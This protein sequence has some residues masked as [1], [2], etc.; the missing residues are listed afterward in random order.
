MPHEL[1]S[2][3][4]LKPAEGRQSFKG[5]DVPTIESPK[6]GGAIKSIDEKFSVNTVN[7]TSGISIP[8]PETSGRG[9]TPSLSLSY[10]SGS[11]NGPFGLGWD[12]SL[13]SIS[14]STSRKLPLYEDEEES[15][16]FL[17][18]EAEDLVPQF[19][20]DTQGKLVEDGKG[21]YVLEK[22]VSGK[23]LVQ[24]YLPRTEGAF[25]RIEK[26]TDREIGV[27]FWRVTS[28]A[29]VTTYFGL[30]DQ[31][32]ISDPDQ[33]GHTFQWL[34]E[35]VVDHTGSCVRYQYKQDGANRFLSK[36]FY[37]NKQPFDVPLT[38]D[39][40][41][42]VLPGEEAFF[43]C[44]ALDY[45]DFSR[46]GEESK[47][48]DTRPDCFSSYRSGFEIRT[49]RL[50]R[51]FLLFHHF[52]ELG[53]RTLVSSLDLTYKQDECL[54]LLES[55][56]EKG[57][58]R[59]PDG[60]YSEKSLPSQVFTY[61]THAWNT[62]V[63]TPVSD[64]QIPAGL[65]G[66]WQLTDLHNEGIP[67]LL[68]ETEGVWFYKRNLGDGQ[69]GEAV[70]VLE[71]PS[72][73]SSQ[74]LQF[75]DLDGDGR[76]QLVSLKKGN[77]G[78][79]PM[80]DE[81]KWQAFHHFRQ[82]PN[83][84][85]SGADVRSID[86]TGDGRA[87]LLVTEDYALTWYASAGKDGYGERVSIPAV[88]EENDGPALMFSDAGQSIFL[89]DM[90]GDGRADIV[91]IRPGE[92]CYW[93]NLGY[94]RFGKKITMGNAP[95]FDSPESFDA[96]RIML[97]D[98]DGTGPADLVYCGTHGFRIWLN[99]CGNAFKAE[100]FVIDGFPDIHSLSDVVLAD[101]LGTGTACIVWSSSLEKDRGTN[102]R[103][104]DLMSSRKPY[105]MTG[106][107][108][109]MGKEIHLEYKPSTAFY[110][111]DLK[112]GDPWAETV[113]FPVHC[114]R[115]VTTKD[116]VTGWTAAHSYRYRDAVYDHDEKEFRGFSYVE[117]KDIEMAEAG[118]AFR[119]RY[120]D[121]DQE[122]VLSRSWI[123]SGT[124]RSGEVPI[125]ASKL[126]PGFDMDSLSLAERRQA[127]R[128][129][130]GT[131]LKSEVWDEDG[132]LYQRITAQNRVELVQPKGQN[133]F[134]V[135]LQVPVETVTYD[136]EKNSEDPRI[137][138]SLVLE[139]DEYGNTL[140]SVQVAYP[141]MAPDLTLP[142]MARECQAKTV[143]LYTRNRL[144]CD[145]NTPDTYLL[146]QPS[147]SM[148]FEVRAPGRSGAL[149]CSDDFAE[150]EKLP[151]TLQGH[152]KILY[153]DKTL[154]NALPLHSIAFP[155]LVF[156]SYQMVGEQ[157]LYDE[158]FQG[159]VTP[160]MLAQG[161]Y[162]QEQD[163]SW[164]ARSGQV[165]Y[166][167]EGE[168]ADVAKTRFYSPVSYIDAFGAE[169]FV[170]YYRNY[171]LLVE[172]V[173][174]SLGNVS[175]VK[176]FDFRT[177]QAKRVSDLNG[178]QTEALYDELGM[179][180][181]SAVLGKGTEADSLEGQ[182]EITSA[183]EQKMMDQLLAAQD[184]LEIT[185]IAR[186]L[187]KKASAR[188]LY[189]PHL[190]SETGKPLATIGIVREE[191]D[192]RNPD[193][194]LQVSY[195]Y[196]S[197]LGVSILVKVQAE[198]APDSRREAGSFR[199]LGNGR[200]I[201]NNKGNAVMEFDPYFSDTPRYEDSAE[202]VEQGV[203]PILH[204]DPLGRLV[205]IDYPDGTFQKE[206]FDPWTV[207]S[208]DS[209]DCVMESAWYTKHRGDEAAAQSEIDAGT[210]SKICY[211]ALGQPAV[212]IEYL[213]NTAAERPEE[214]ITQAV[215]DVRGN[216][217]QVVDP[218]GNTVVSYKYDLLDRPLFQEGMDDGCRWMITDMEGKPVFSWDERGFEFE[219]RYDILK[220]PVL[221]IVRNKAEGWEKIVGRTVYGEDLL[222][223]DQSNKGA[224][225][226]R[227]LLG[228]VVRAYDTAGLA[229]TEAYD[230]QYLP[231]KTVRRLARDY[232]GMVDWTED[233]LESALEQERF[234]SFMK[235]DALGR[236]TEQ[237]MPDGSVAVSA[238]NEGGLLTSQT[239]SFPGRDE[240]VI[241]LRKVIYN[242][243]RQREYVSY[244]N[245]V[246]IRYSFDPLTER[247]DRIY[248]TRKDG[249]VLQDLN[250][251]YDAVGRVVRI[252]DKSIPTTFYAGQRVDGESR[253]TYDSL[254]RLVS[255]T[256][257]ENGAAMK[258]AATDN[259]SDAGYCH[260]M[261]KG[262]SMAMHN[263]M[264]HFSYDAA[265]NILQIR[266]TAGSGSWTRNFAY[267][268]RSNRLLYTELGD[269]KFR[270]EYHERHGFITA[271]PHLSGIGWDAFERMVSSSRQERSDG[272]VPETT[273]YQYDGQGTRIR[274]ITECQTAPGAA[275][276]VKSQRIYL[277]SYEK[278]LCDW[279]ANRGLVRDS[280][281][282]LDGGHRFVMVER[283]NEVDDG[284]ARE[285]VRYE[286]VNHLGSSCLELDQH[287]EV[288]SY[289]EYHPY[290]T[291]AFQ[292][293]NKEIKAAAKRY[294]FTGME[295]DDETGLAYHAARYY[296][297]W[298]GR[299][300]SCD[301][302]GIEGGMNLYC[303]CDD[304]PTSLFDIEGR[305]PHG[306]L[307]DL[308]VQNG[309]SIKAPEKVSTFNS[310]LI[311][312]TLSGFVKSAQSTLNM[313]SHPI[314]TG[315]ALVNTI[316]HPI[317]TL[318][319]AQDDFAKKLE[320]V[321]KLCK[322]GTIVDVAYEIGESVG[323]NVFDKTVGMAGSAVGIMGKSVLTS[324]RAQ[325]YIDPTKKYITEKKS[326]LQ[327]KV[328]QSA[329][330][331]VVN[332]VQEFNKKAGAKI[333]E[334]TPTASIAKKQNAL[335]LDIEKRKGQIAD[336]K[337]EREQYAYVIS[338]N[339]RDAVMHQ[340]TKNR[341][342]TM[343]DQRAYENLSERIEMKEE[344]LMG[345]L[346]QRARLE[347]ANMMLNKMTG[348]VYKKMESKVESM[349]KDSV[350]KQVD[351]YAKG[352]SPRGYS[353]MAH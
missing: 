339:K 62:R 158:A 100:P 129:V 34:P 241:P 190:F 230:F 164:W 35:L 269:S 150:I 349:V 102:L 96:R 148:S 110:L 225:Q 239:L 272:G 143:L 270:Y 276:Q 303:Y 11:G 88:L 262:D 263:Y 227:N 17:F 111:E 328:E 283:R 81:G 231:V 256:G 79:F 304:N 31:A 37:G 80:D 48:W 213:R 105:L 238:F 187:L 329:V 27:S 201:F 294:R 21:G 248:S 54:T 6:G 332:N 183:A 43:F 290:G 281:S 249:D 206:E 3:S 41:G 193:S 291:T 301:P 55:A 151:M 26:Y 282:I 335:D 23:Y 224:L 178:N 140:R 12:L 188:Y 144:T 159:R 65:G 338:P 24:R 200:T 300:L 242:A 99:A 120:P 93:P 245:G 75:S 83:I 311:K 324:R 95:V 56:T 5:I 199:W 25:L 223:P 171:Y 98:I 117:E 135:F 325:K 317:D 168:S 181:A 59:Q 101:L 46:Y 314:E 271:M 9:L 109:S 321:E 94:G 348:F 61:E 103:Y 274:K 217:L 299:W 180:K 296:I 67:G 97:S 127:V 130:R 267:G 60:S 250:Y 345:V 237:T 302:I 145:I 240:T 315:K 234:T 222:A 78:Y 172:R 194:R 71:K 156:E 45:G 257:R 154:R 40:A 52:E 212:M 137:S 139:T 319:K 136:L 125:S 10:S 119:S 90:S 204:Y 106:Y 266:H 243:K 286:L 87:D 19:R 318:H 261:Q 15:D 76:K 69:F 155:D 82:L 265:G 36:V 268:E 173:T 166:L 260:A 251:T 49:K 16:T 253:Y 351:D 13:G 74:G 232:K 8:V 185:R 293:N 207:C 259:Y 333:G 152:S 165:R 133:P 218:R 85:L 280:V 126:L 113:H 184:S 331:H 203:S 18:S 122:P 310:A 108:N 312:G 306:A 84:D 307:G 38:A 170:D 209:G 163:G 32:R 219:T 244:G 20:K 186:T 226:E 246:S 322:T 229:E 316:A 86:L 320:K 336:L 221:E 91:R 189:F 147:E 298:L 252:L 92:V 116:L 28:G 115:K 285:L 124:V 53:G 149:Y 353:G 112:S 254:G 211:D 162:V 42:I 121:L 330:M 342:N 208:Y 279:G 142:A 7:G 167:R 205:R 58:I 107:S 327:N 14:R 214:M 174:D 287:A 146:R 179:V 220:R 192:R 313:V 202:M 326:V 295:R 138:Q 278:Y 68:Y 131:V 50:C 22:K 215:R 275:P 29:F 57:Y 236:I 228:N 161:R 191:F 169:T 128:C 73:G 195:E 1:S 343:S 33:P 196:S 346:D 352:V 288:I 104:I 247:I 323:S 273:Y 118:E 292:A 344:A 141:R 347:T 4:F 284:T 153:Y 337:R 277:G 132:H 123:H 289:E 89:A 63:H 341:S 182:D 47:I 210:P 160:E 39:P 66:G 72:A 70:K 340:N 44:I 197:G 216:I 297:P 157:G 177:L 258:M 2:G 134:A 305:L 176:S 350:K 235:V 334:Y 114:L 51:R 175:E 308:A 30:T 233:R 309:R 64:P 77:Q 264:Q 198:N 255:A